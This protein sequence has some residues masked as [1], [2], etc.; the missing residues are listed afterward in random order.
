[1]VAQNQGLHEV[2]ADVTA[3]PASS[4]GVVNDLRESV[5]VPLGSDDAVAPTKRSRRAKVVMAAMLGAALLVA[6]G[7]Y[8]YGL[9]RTSTDDAQIEGHVSPVAVRV[10]GQIAAIKVKDNQLVNPGDVLVELD[11]RDFEVKLAI[12]NADVEASKAALTAAEQQRDVVRGTAAAQGAQARGGLTQ[13]TSQV[14]TAR[15]LIWQ[16]QSDLSALEAKKKL[17]ASELARTKSLVQ[18]G[19]LSQGELESRQ[20]AY[21]QA[22]AYVREARAR[23]AIA[24]SGVTAGEGGVELAQGRVLAAETA[25]QQ[26]A[27]AEAAVALARARLDQAEANRDLAQLN[28][29]YTHVVSPVRGVVG[30]RTA[31]VGQAV[32]PERVL[33]AIVSLD[34]VWVV[35]N[36]KEDQVVKI[37]PGVPVVARVD[38]IGKGF[39]GHVESIGPGT[40]SRFALIPPDNASGNFVKVVQRVPVLIRLDEPP[41][42]A[43]A[44]GMNV[45]VTAHLRGR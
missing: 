15:A 12:A 29:S 23:L 14:S 33:M 13:A 37:R 27:S 44:L 11:S 38:A 17:A 9:F 18:S 21:D 10:A 5:D 43:L 16:A 3:S 8:V 20:A 28:L 1:M 26:E 7:V 32:G 36:F 25:P 45:E 40:G 6:V 35:A 4:P 2:T 19:A 22:S 34:D 41:P 39:R 24:S 31:E 42:P 30:R